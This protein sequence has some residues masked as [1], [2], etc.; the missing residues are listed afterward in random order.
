[1]PE[2]LARLCWSLRKSAT[3]RRFRCYHRRRNHHGCPSQNLKPIGRGTYGLVASADD[4]ILGRK[5]AIKR[6]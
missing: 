2:L 1:M 6:T 5:V 3:A 4:V